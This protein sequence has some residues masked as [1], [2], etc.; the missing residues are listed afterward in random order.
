MSR[1]HL[2]NPIKKITTTKQQPPPPKHQNETRIAKPCNYEESKRLNQI[3]C[4]KTCKI[5]NNKI[6]HV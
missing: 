3:G 2:K 1:K 5:L 4:N 6:L